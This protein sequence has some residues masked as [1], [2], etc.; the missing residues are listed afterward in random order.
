MARVLRSLV[1]F[2]S[3][4]LLMASFVRAGAD[5]PLTKAARAD[6]MTSVR[7]LIESRAD[8]NAQ[9]G[10]G[11]TAL[12]WAAHNL[13]AD[14]VRALLAAG[15]KPDVANNFGVTPLLEASRVGDVVTME[16]LLKAGADPKR[17]HT[18]GETPLMAVARSG[19]AAGVK[20]LLDRGVDV[21]AA[22]TYLKQTALMWAAAEG[23]TE[24][25]EV[26]LKAGADP[27]IKAHV[28]TL[29][30]GGRGG[31]SD[32]PTGGFTALMFAARHGQDD[33]LRALAKGGADLNLRNADNATAMI[34]AIY[35]YRFD[36]G[37]LL[38][39]L[40][41]DVNDGSL[42]VAV[43]MRQSVT[44]QFAFDGSRLRPNH[45]NKLSNVDLI[46]HLMKKGADPLKAYTG[47]FHS[48]SMPN[49]ENISGN[50]FFLAVA[51]VDAEALRVMVENGA[52]PNALP[53]AAPAAGPGGPGGPGGGGPPRGGARGAPGGGGGGP[54]QPAVITVMTGGAR[55]VGRTGGPGYVGQSTNFREPGSRT[56]VDAAIVLVKGGANPNTKGGDGQSLLHQAV[57]LNNLELIKALAAAKVDFLQTNNDGLTALEMAEGKAPVGGRGGAG[58][59]GA[60]PMAG[61]AITAT[62]GK[63]A[64][65]MAGPGSSGA[66]ALAGMTPDCA[67]ISPP[68]MT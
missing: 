11:S 12:L 13:N 59:R 66:S 18:E 43:V 35:N 44:D 47:K 10:D 57:N 46:A 32:H 17:T 8:V 24:A 56:G 31:N 5:S 23:N 25:V 52:N 38:A 19:N 22:D 27:N 45:A 14:M 36:T 53:P 28:S 65:A 7:K 15:A 48:W 26:L 20:L 3:I 49:S 64:S 4:A 50:P 6:D 62:G 60:V 40:G 42:V 39:D 34:I 2:A 63:P 68:S 30:S 16:L 54:A 1:L 41:A 58:A 67:R 29:T 9:A 33:T 61:G 51:Q 21:N 55:G 37:A